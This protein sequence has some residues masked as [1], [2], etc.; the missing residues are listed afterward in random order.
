MKFNPQTRQL[1]TDDGLL[2]KEMHCP[3]QRDQIKLTLKGLKT[4]NCSVCDHTLLLAHGYTEQEL[5]QHLQ[6]EPK[7][8]LLVDLSQIPLTQGDEDVRQP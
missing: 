4:L 1:F 6:N 7:T 2:I 5:V 8:C 3:Y